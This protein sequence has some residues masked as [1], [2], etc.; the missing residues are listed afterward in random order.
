M[1]LHKI[2]KEKG[3]E[4]EPFEKNVAQA[5]A[6]LEASGSEI[7]AELKELFISAAKEVECAGGKT[8]VVIFVPY[9]LLQKFH[10]IQTRLVRELEKK[11]SGKPVIIVAQR[12]ILPREKN[13]SRLQKQKRPRSRTLTSV[14]D[15]IL[16]DLVFPTEIVAKRVRYKVDG[17][18]LLRVFLDPKDQPNIEYKTQTFQ[19]VYKKLTGKDVVFEFPITSE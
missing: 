17:S 3:A 14:H 5:L 18:R 13:G 11:F 2:Q 9:R 7:K 12:R 19:S 4:P 16:E 10:K 8:A 6:D 15:Q 1:V